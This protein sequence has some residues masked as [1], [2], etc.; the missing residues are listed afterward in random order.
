MLLAEY[1][2]GRKQLRKMVAVLDDNDY[3]DRVDRKKL[4]SAIR[5]MDFVIEWLE[6]GVF[7]VEN[8]LWR[9]SY[10][11]MNKAKFRAYTYADSFVYWDD[12]MGGFISKSV[13][14]DEYLEVDE[15]IDRELEAERYGTS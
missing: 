13:Y 1:K 8:P 6:T 3:R 4:N 2:D 12:T 15:K 5:D 7:P 11:R 10:G 9:S 14:K